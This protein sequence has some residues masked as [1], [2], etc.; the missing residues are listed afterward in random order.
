[1]LKKKA[2]PGGEGFLPVPRDIPVDVNTEQLFSEEQYN[3]A[4]VNPE[5]IP[6]D[7]L[8]NLRQDWIEARMR[9]DPL[10]IVADDGRMFYVSVGGDGKALTVHQV[11]PRYE[12]QEGMMMEYAG[13]DAF[14]TLE[15]S[16]GRYQ[17][18]P[19]NK[20]QDSSVEGHVAT[21]R[22]PIWFRAIQHL[23]EAHARTMDNPYKK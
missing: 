3:L 22:N 11:V 9:G 1:M 12:I 5:A 14:F 18:V 13:P 4:E 2:Q 15:E 21:V 16:L 10:Y 20:I 23:V 8:N 17:V 6:P 7:D 19:M